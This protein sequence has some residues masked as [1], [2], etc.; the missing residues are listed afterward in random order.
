MNT[1]LATETLRT[2]EI[3]T[4]ECVVPP[5]STREAQIRPFLAHKPGNYRAHIEAALT[6]QCDALETRFYIGLLNGEMVG[7]IMTVETGG[8]GIFGH[9]HTREDQRRKGICDAIMRHQMADFRRRDGQALLLGTGY[10]SPAY[11]IYAT[12]GFR[13]WP[14]GKPGAMRYD[15][16]PQEAFEAEFFAPAPGN[17][18][19]PAQWR[20]WP[21]VALLATVPTPVTLRS[22]TLNLWGVGLLEGAYSQFLHAYGSRPD[23]CAAV[24]ES[25]TGAV[26]ALA[27][28]V[29]DS[30]WPGTQLLDL[31]AHP[32]ATVEDLARLLQSLPLPASPIQ[33]YADTRD[34]QKIGALEALGFRKAAVLPNQFQ[35]QDIQ[36]DV[37]LYA[38]P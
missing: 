30:R 1:T 23:A 8:I 7:N 13:D 14:V 20:H 6:G 19:V 21:L 25:E 32:V 38:R 31:F 2:G 16:A 36:R 15:T 33:S 12:H 27:T 28:C 5:E 11:R 3:L 29:P 35:E 24:L 4:I 9:V 37:W 17:K 10:Q 18:P 22:L 34:T 26:T